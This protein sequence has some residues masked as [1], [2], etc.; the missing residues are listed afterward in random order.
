MA[1]YTTGTSD[2]K[3]KKAIKWWLFGLIGLL[4]FEYFYVGKIKAGLIKLV[5]GLLC[6]IGFYAIFTEEPETAPVAIII[7]LILALPNLF[8]L[9]LGTFR[10]NV[11]NALRE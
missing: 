2:K 4:G 9:L 1:N 3:K 8:R 10:D 11:G 5:I 7:W 6:A